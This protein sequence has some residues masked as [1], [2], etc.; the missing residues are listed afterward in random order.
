MLRRGIIAFGE[1]TKT[2]KS[3]G[4]ELAAHVTDIEQTVRLGGGEGTGLL[5]TKKDEEAFMSPIKG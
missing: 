3:P 2:V 1:R 4:G 5:C